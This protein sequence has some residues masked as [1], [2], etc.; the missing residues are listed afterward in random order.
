MPH[1]SDLLVQLAAPSAAPRSASGPRRALQAERSR[2]RWSTGA[3]L[4]VLYGL[5][6]CAGSGSRPP[7][8]A[9]NRPS[10]SASAPLAAADIA[11]ATAWNYRAPASC[12]SE[13]RL[14]E[15][16]ARRVPAL[17]A[18][19]VTRAVSSG[20][21]IDV[22]Q[23]GGEWLGRVA[24]QSNTDSVSR[25]VTGADC[26]EVVVALALITSL[27]LRPRDEAAEI[28][29]PAIAAE[30][31]APAV[32]AESP[33]RDAALVATRRSAWAEG[34]AR[35]LPGEPRDASGNAVEAGEPESVDDSAGP[36]NDADGGDAENPRLQIAGLLGYAAQPA[37]AFSARLQLERWGSASASSWSS[38][39]GVGYAEGRHENDRLGG[40]ALRLFHGQIELCP[41]G[42]DVASTAWVRAC[43]HGRAGALRF[44]ADTGRLPDAR[45]LWRPWAALGTSVHLG[46]PVSSSLSLRLFAELSLVLVRDEFATERPLAAGEP[47]P[48]DVSTFYEISPVSF[49]VGL[50]AAHVF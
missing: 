19:D 29:A 40:A 6:A 15:Q 28:P 46:V 41:P 14:F 30:S 10:Q 35:S 27:W 48:A 31:T 16:I 11:R 21:D 44:S 47:S 3:T 42:L 1:A 26:D 2:R 43:A 22:R 5:T 45:S 33:A 23:S 32:A 12:P 17:T 20:V 9:A 25:E 49:D 34:A 24:F 37:G 18:S 38:A 8:S 4:L 36:S 39:L 50:G 13:A 7:P